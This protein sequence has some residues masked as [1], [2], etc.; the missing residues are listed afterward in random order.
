MRGPVLSVVLAC[1]LSPASLG[2]S[3]NVDYGAG[4]PPADYGAAGLPGTWNVVT[5][6]PHEAQALVNL[7]GEPTAATISHDGGAPFLLNDQATMGN[8]ERLL[9]DGLGDMG[10]VV[11]TLELDGLMNG[12]YQLIVYGWTPTMPTDMIGVHPY[13][14]S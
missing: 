5:G 10:D 14:I 6:G 8:D 9:D 7:M 1:L 13:T 3:M 2:Q 11:V 4:G 12:T